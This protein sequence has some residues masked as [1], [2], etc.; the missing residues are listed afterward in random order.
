MYVLDTD[1]M[2]AL[3]W[4]SGAAGQRLIARLNKLSEGEAAT[5][6][7]TFEEQTRGWLAV[8]A[9]SRSL[10]EQ[11]DCP[12]M[13][14]PHASLQTRQTRQINQ[15]RERLRCSCST[16]ITSACWSGARTR[17]NFAATLERG[18]AC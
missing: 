18:F 11:V 8:L 17:R 7:I 3:E 9:Q 12:W 14:T 1:H 10:D 2:S 4:G 6:I 15:S 16:P 13:F 5:T